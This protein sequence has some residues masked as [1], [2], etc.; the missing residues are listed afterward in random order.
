MASRIEARRK[1]ESRDFT[2]KTLP[3]EMSTEEDPSPLNS[4]VRVKSE[5]SKPAR[6]A[7]NGRQHLPEIEGSGKLVML[8]P[9]LS[10]M[11]VVKKRGNF[12]SFLYGEKN[13]SMND[14]MRT[15]KLRKEQSINTANNTK[16]P[17][18]DRTSK[19]N[20]DKNV[21]YGHK[22]LESGIDPI[23]KASSYGRITTPS[24][25]K[26]RTQKGNGAPSPDK[27]FVK[28]AND[29]A[30]KVKPRFPGN[31]NLAPKRLT[32]APQIEKISTSVSLL[33]VPHKVE[34]SKCSNRKNGVVEAYA[35]NSDQGLVREYNE[36][37][38]SIILNI[39]QPLHSSYKGE[40][41]N[42]S[43]FGIYDGHGG[44][45]CADFLKDTLHRFVIGN[46]N[47]PE[48][49]QEALVQGFRE[50]E[51]EFTNLAQNDKYQ[52]DQSG[53]CAIVALIISN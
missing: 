14:S 31:M 33:P 22:P 30:N 29:I 53:S 6:V 7:V 19:D 13:N 44:A 36:D 12:R 3:T 9:L 35:A 21:A 42:C 26:L 51:K 17:G 15:N 47:F 32:P 20:M 16:N 50:A 46:K 27:S 18:N 40:W 11:P 4:K 24:P 25:L 10:Q 39:A 2:Q 43:F 49:P 28:D 8:A 34:P 5:P 52:V 45:K 37:R 48:Y 41:P 1:R 38:V 23:G